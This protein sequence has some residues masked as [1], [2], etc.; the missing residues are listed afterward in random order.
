MWIWKAVKTVLSGANTEREFLAFSIKQYKV[1]ERVLEYERVFIGWPKMTYSRL[2][3][4]SLWH[5]LSC[6]Q[7]I[8]AEEAHSLCFQGAGV[9]TRPGTGWGV[10]SVVMAKT[11]PVDLLLLFF[12]K[13]FLVASCVELRIWRHVNR[14]RTDCC[15]APIPVKE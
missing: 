9:T 13:N 1:L 4:L 8:W 14:G 3:E 11:V 12:L 2:K 7:F 5:T 6:G 10:E 15:N